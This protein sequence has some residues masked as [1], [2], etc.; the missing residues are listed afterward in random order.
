MNDIQ[1]REI[2]YCAIRKSQKA[3]KENNKTD[4]QKETKKRKIG[5]YNHGSNK[6]IVV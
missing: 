3:N 2:V 5:N 6:K 4:Q 1:E